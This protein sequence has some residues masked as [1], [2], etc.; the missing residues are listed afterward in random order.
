[1]EGVY[2]PSM[3]LQSLSGPALFVLAKLHTPQH[4]LVQ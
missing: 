2:P 3:L 4:S 1:M